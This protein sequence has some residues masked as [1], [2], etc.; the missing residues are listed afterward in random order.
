M[1]LVISPRLV[2]YKVG[3]VVEMD[4]VTARPYVKGGLLAV[5]PEPEPEPVEKVKPAKSV[6]K[7]VTTKDVD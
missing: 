2:G 5:V 4:D 1:F 6:A 7:T 3:D